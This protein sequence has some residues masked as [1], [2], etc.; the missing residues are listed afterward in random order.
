MYDS[1]PLYFNAVSNKCAIP[2]VNKTIRLEKHLFRKHLTLASIL[3]FSNYFVSTH[4]HQVPPFHP[5]THRLAWFYR[6]A[7]ISAMCIQQKDAQQ[8]RALLRQPLWL[9]L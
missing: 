2:A 5:Q 6:Q 9:L 4:K 7:S 3:I 8:P 1:S